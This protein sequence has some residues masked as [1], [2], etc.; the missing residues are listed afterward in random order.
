MNLSFDSTATIK[1]NALGDIGELSDIPMSFQM[2]NNFSRL[3]MELMGVKV[4]QVTA[5]TIEWSYD[6]FSQG[7]SFESVDKS[8]SQNNTFSGHSQYSLEEYLKYNWS[9]QNVKEIQ[10]LD[11]LDVFE[12]DLM[13]EDQRIVKL[14]LDNHTYL[15]LSVE[16]NG[17][18]DYFLDYRSIGDSYF[19]YYL[20]SSENDGVFTIRINSVIFL[21]EEDL[22][23]Y[24][25]PKEASEEFKDFI[26]AKNQPS[27]IQLLYDQGQAFLQASKNDSAI[28]Y[29]DQALA[30]NR[31]DLLVLEKR[32]EAKS[33]AGDQYGAISDFNRVIEL[34]SEREADDFNNLGIAKYRLGDYNG[35]KEDYLMAM[36]LDSMSENIYKNMGL[37]MFQYDDFEA[38]VENYKKAVNLD[39][40]DSDSY[41]YIGAANAN[42]GSYDVALTNY[43]KSMELG[44]EGDVIHNSMGVSYYKLEDYNSAIY[45]FKKAIEKDSTNDQYV[46]NL[47]NTY[48]ALEDYSLAI[49]N[50]KSL[51]ERDETYHGVWAALSTAYLSA[52]SNDGAL[53]AINKALELFPDSA[54]YFA[55]RAAVYE[56]KGQYTLAIDDYTSAINLQQAAYLYLNRGLAQQNL[57]NKFEACKDYK[58]A[59]ELGAEEAEDF[60]VEQCKL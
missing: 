39:S 56:Q 35:A 45:A 47:A 14:F 26:A 60:L 46:M 55:Q 42:L 18:R 38:V 41:F 27:Q 32:G 53:N 49:D 22:E 10:F 50:F 37:L 21:N 11:S 31:N 58:K 40:L 23:A 29:F 59:A 13:S 25:V 43:M 1:F 7:Y 8:Q 6:P 3:E 51:L 17:Q 12:V 19:P 20:K 5:D 2:K 54:E 52:S 44:E 16:E 36:S 24:S 57:S 9:V 48:V 34:R 28:Y 33:A 30:L 15:T 4:I